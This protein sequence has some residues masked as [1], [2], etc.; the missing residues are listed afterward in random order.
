MLAIAAA[1]LAGAIGAA[2]GFDG[3]G[4]ATTA[5][6]TGP[7][8]D[9]AGP[10]SDSSSAPDGALTDGPLVV[11]EG[12]TS[13][14]LDDDAGIPAEVDAGS[15][16]GDGGTVEACPI[17]QF[18]C[19]ATGL[20]VAACGACVG[21]R[22]GCATTKTCVNDCTTCAN[23]TFGCVACGGT[24]RTTIS[25]SVCQKDITG[26]YGNGRSHCSCTNQGGCYTANQV[27]ATT[28]P[29]FGYDCYACGE[30]GTDT[31]RCYGGSNRTCDAPINKC[32]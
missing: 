9:E 23:L 15:D 8:L 24:F 2:C 7:G 17:D 4:L 31:L 20:C 18:R 22:L 21:A 25:R 6:G 5:D 30:S 14:Q 19:A 27:C 26:C 13:V 10:K 29:F 11:N 16:G 12:G 28:N 3:A 1:L 32:E